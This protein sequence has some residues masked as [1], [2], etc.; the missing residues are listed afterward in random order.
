MRGSSGHNAA[1]RAGHEPHAASRL[2]NKG[3]ALNGNAPSFVPAT[4]HTAMNG[5]GN[6]H[7]GGN[8]YRNAAAGLLATASSGESG[9]PNGVSH[10]SCLSPSFATSSK[11]RQSNVIV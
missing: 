4:G 11:S 8:S 1:K 3:K 2:G 10:V 5:N 9:E 6:G 7:P